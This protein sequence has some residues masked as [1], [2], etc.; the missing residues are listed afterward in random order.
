MYKKTI[1]YMDYNGIDRTEDFFFNFTEAE[2][3]E[4]QMSVNG[5]YAEMIQRIADSKDIN[6]LINVL[7]ELICKSYG[8]K[9]D[10]GRRFIKKP[11]LT[12]E[13]TQTPAYSALYM[14]LATDEKK[15]A[16]FINKVIPS[17]LAAK[18]EKAKVENLMADNKPSGT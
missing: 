11:E 4:L 10:D 9:S 5:G 6:A 7:K 13:F 8:I 3:T 15:A 1:T 14:E 16:E 2:L 17:N 18:V 12:E